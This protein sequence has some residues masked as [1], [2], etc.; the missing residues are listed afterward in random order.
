MQ[1]LAIKITY[2]R[3]LAYA[4][5]YS[6]ALSQLNAPTENIFVAVNEYWPLR[7]MFFD[8]RVRL[9]LHPFRGSSWWMT[10]ALYKPLIDSAKGAAPYA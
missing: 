1:T 7:Y 3:S 5:H 10:A 2:L 9:P 8:I 6:V 4:L